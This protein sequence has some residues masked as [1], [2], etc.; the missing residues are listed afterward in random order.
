MAD[1]LRALYDKMVTVSSITDLVGT[2]IYLSEAPQRATLPF[3]TYRSVSSQHDR[4]FEGRSRLVRSRVQMDAYDKTTARAGRLSVVAIAN[5]VRAGLDG[6]RG[7]VSGV[8]FKAVMVQGDQDLTEPGTRVARR[9]FDLM[10][11]HDAD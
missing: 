9:T 10:I 6:F 8:A 11:W 2:R 3:I 7:T 5:A 1:M 4:S